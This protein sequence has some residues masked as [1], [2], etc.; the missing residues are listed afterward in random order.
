[1]F[2]AHV[3]GRRRNRPQRRTPQHVLPPGEVEEIGQI[4]VTAT[5]LA[6]GERPGSSLEVV[7]QPRFETFQVEPFLRPD[8][9][10]LGVMDRHHR[11][12]SKPR[13]GP[14]CPVPRQCTW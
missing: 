10:G 3:V 13:R 2:A 11:A 5:K 1:M 9:H 4:G 6:N 7:T 14:P 12:F 8:L